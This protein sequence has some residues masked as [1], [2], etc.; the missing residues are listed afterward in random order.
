MAMGQAWLDRSVTPLS[1]CRK[2]LEFDLVQAGE[3]MQ[4]IAFVRKYDNKSTGMHARREWCKQTHGRDRW[5]STN[6]FTTDQHSPESNGNCM[7][8]LEKEPPSNPPDGQVPHWKAW[9][10][11]GETQLTG[12]GWAVALP[13][14]PYKPPDS[15]VSSK[16]M[17]S[18]PT[19]TSLRSHWHSCFSWLQSHVSLL[20]QVKWLHLSGRESLGYKPFTALNGKMRWV[21][22]GCGLR[23]AGNIINRCH[24]ALEAVMSQSHQCLWSE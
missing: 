8:G 22:T 24:R 17:L 5:S 1:L 15:S 14:Q 4:R 6:S 18:S 16:K 2:K 13:L 12:G 19:G 20:S 10:T 7:Y 11:C 3:R 9:A 21:E 23:S